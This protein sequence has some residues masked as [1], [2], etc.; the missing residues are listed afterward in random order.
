MN[1]QLQNTLVEHLN[2]NWQTNPAI[3]TLVH[4]Y[5]KY[6][7][8]LVITGGI[9][10]LVSLVLTVYFWLRFKKVAKIRKFKWPFEKKVYFALGSVLTIFCLFFALVWV[11]NLST[12][13]KPLPGL[14]TLASY[15]AVPSDSVSGKALINW[16]ESGSKTFPP[17]LK[18][19]VQDRIE[20]QRP[21]AIICGILLVVFII[22]TIRV[23]DYLI[24]KSRDSDSEWTIKDRVLILG[25]SAT[26]VCCL[27]LAIMVVANTQGAI[28]PITISLLGAGN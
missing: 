3:R 5:T 21:K 10:L 2:S 6:H 16:V 1:S 9:V 18:A 7:A 25:G 12:A 24:T 15:T 14:T 19:K 23:W 13:L 20:W 22:G 28:G 26:F 8:V 17:A 27:L 4:D 11:A